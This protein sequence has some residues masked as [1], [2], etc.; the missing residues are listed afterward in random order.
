M[1]C[2]FAS[3]LNHEFNEIYGPPAHV[4]LQGAY[5]HVNLGETAWS[6]RVD[7]SRDGWRS[8]HKT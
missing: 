1:A 3:R 4:S 7:Q 8:Q 2:H 6:C 5:V